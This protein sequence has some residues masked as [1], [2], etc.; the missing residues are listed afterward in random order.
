MSAVVALLLSLLAS[1]VPQK[2]RTIREFAEQEIILPAGGPFGGERLKI[3]RLP[4][5]GLWLDAISNSQY[6]RFL[7]TG[8]SQGGKTLLGSAVPVLY[9]L[10]ECRET[11]IYAA[12]TLQMAMDKWN[13]DIL[14][15]IKFSKYKDLLPTE[16]K[17]SQG[18]DVTSIQ[19]KNGATL[20]FMTGGGSDKSVA[21]YTSR[22]VVITEIDGMDEASESS[23]EADRISQLEARTKAF[24]DRAR[25]Y[26]E[27]TVSTEEGRTWK[28]LKNGTNHRIALP[29][30]HCKEYVTPERDDLKGWQDAENIVAAAKAAALCCPKC[31]AIWNEQDRRQANQLG[32][33]AAEGQT[34]GKSGTISGEPKP[35][36][37]FSFRFNA[38]NNLFTTI[39]GIAENEW[40]SPRQTQSDLAERELRQF[41]WAMPSE[42]RT[43]TL[44]EMD[45]HAICRRQLNVARGLVPYGTRLLT[46]GID[47]GKFRHHWVLLAWRSDAAP[48]VVDYGQLETDCG[49]VAEEK[50]IITALREFRDKASLGWP[51][52]QMEG[53]TPEPNMKC[54]YILID[55]GNWS[56]LITPFCAESGPQYV[57][58]KGFGQ[59]QIT[60][61]KALID[62][63]YELVMQGGYYLLEHN[64]DIWKTYVHNR[65]QTPLNQAGALTLFKDEP[66]KHL[67]F[68]KHLTAEVKEE[69]FVPDRGTV[70]K[71]KKIN[72]NNH[73]LDAMALGCL[74]ANAAGISV[75]QPLNVPTPPVQQPVKQG[76]FEMTKQE[77][78][79]RGKG[80]YN[81]WLGDAWN[82]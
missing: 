64:A 55:A 50:G 2:I 62:P 68:G 24:G 65:L 58:C 23:R 11:V 53:R 17:G 35:T 12:P 38:V 15:L 19:F 34:I 54:N 56:K 69:T 46:I 79:S 61:R 31:H 74:G 47:C 82:R 28:E 26:L 44:S 27:C 67:S 39:G 36:N 45:A 5:C 48:H 14:P 43:L 4:W 42:N 6:R 41:L 76:E 59:G 49:Q 57:P 10:F 3:A 63:G 21:G 22:V 71:W 1:V 20:R 51:V 13:R 37:T 33:L 66:K 16:G 30:P 75:I 70:I 32:R 40:Q 77:E 73:H 25:I 81:S 29:C 7:L 72:D 78:M 18:G 9:H 60:R 52:E 8:V 80:N